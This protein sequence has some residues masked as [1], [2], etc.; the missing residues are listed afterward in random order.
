MVEGIL[1][2]HLPQ[3]AAYGDSHFRVEK[4]VSGERTVTTV[5]QLKTARQRTEE[6]AHML[7]TATETTRQSAE[8]LLEQVREVKKGRS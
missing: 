5:R 3:L 7:G 4:G 2:G 1:F 8:E 6:L